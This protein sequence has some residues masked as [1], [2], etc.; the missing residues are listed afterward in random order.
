MDPMVPRIIRAPWWNE[1]GKNDLCSGRLDNADRVVKARSHGAEDAARWRRSHWRRRR[2]RSKRFV[3]EVIEPDRARP[4][5]SIT[6]K[7]LL[8][9]FPSDA[10][11]LRTLVTDQKRFVSVARLD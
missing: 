5:S 1:E 9:D 6:L 7:P 8:D 11:A 2:V 3:G 10:F 4:P